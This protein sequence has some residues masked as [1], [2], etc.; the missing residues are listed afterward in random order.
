MPAILNFLLFFLSKYSPTSLF[1][2]L[3]AIVLTLDPSGPIKTDLI[4]LSPTTLLFTDF[5]FSTNK[6]GSGLPDPKGDK[7]FILL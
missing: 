4:C 3:K 6:F 7:T 1:V 5:K 2:A